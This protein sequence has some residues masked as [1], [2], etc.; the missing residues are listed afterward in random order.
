MTLLLAATDTQGCTGTLHPPTN[1]GALLLHRAPLILYHGTADEL[2]P[3]SAIVAQAVGAAPWVRLRRAIGDGHDLASLDQSAEVLAALVGEGRTWSE[4]LA[5]ASKTPARRLHGTEFASETAGAGV[6]VEAAQE[7]M[8]KS[9]A[10]KCA[11][12]EAA[13]QMIARAQQPHQEDE[14]LGGV[15]DNE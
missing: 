1:A 12:Q 6:T 5:S 10:H 14:Q 8:R 3:I 7:A 15:S 9:M 13:G 4:Q 11:L 2:N